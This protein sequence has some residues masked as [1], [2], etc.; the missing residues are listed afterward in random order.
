MR[1]GNAV[2]RWLSLDTG[3][4]K[5]LVRHDAADGAAPKRRAIGED[6][7]CDRAVVALQPRVPFLA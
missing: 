7:S 4:D 2:R 6:D 5:R 3:V 1:S